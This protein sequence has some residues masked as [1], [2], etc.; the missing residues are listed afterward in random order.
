MGL[1]LDHDVRTEKITLYNYKGVF[2][3]EESY[4]NCDP[5]PLEWLEL[6]ETK[7]NLYQIFTE[8][9]QPETGYT[10]LST[11]KELDFLEKARKSNLNYS[12]QRSTFSTN[13]MKSQ[14]NSTVGWMNNNK[15]LRV[16]SAKVTRI[17]NLMG[18]NYDNIAEEEDESGE[19]TASNTKGKIIRPQTVGFGN[20]R[21][22]HQNHMFSQKKTPDTHHVGVSLQM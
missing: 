4:Y 7:D 18:A 2:F 15:M 11:V 6:F 9:S 21:Q 22:D 8:E 12:H 10:P 1:S 5:L 16:S 13:M 14:S 19:A 3:P 17:P 20:K